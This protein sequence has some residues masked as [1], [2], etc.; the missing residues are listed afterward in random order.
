MK[1]PPTSHYPEP[2]AL[3]PRKVRRQIQFRAK[4]VLL[5]AATGFAFLAAEIILRLC[6]RPIATLNVETRGPHPDYGFAP[7]ASATGRFVRSEY[8]VGFQ[9]TAQRMRGSVIR[10]AERET[11][12]RARILFLGDSFTYS[13][14]TEEK[15]SFTSLL[16]RKWPDIEIIN[17]GCTGYGQREELAVLDKLGGELKPEITVV[18]FF[19]NDLEDVLRT[20]PAYAVNADGKVRRVSPADAPSDPLRLWPAQ[21]SLPQSKWHTCYV[22]ELIRQATAAARHRYTG[23]MRPR[24][25][26]T[27]EA[28]EH[29]WQLLDA[30]FRLIKIRAD[31]IGTRLVVI[32]IPD[33]N[34]VNP[35]STISS[36]KPLNFDVQARIKAVCEKNRIEEHDLL[37]TMQDAFKANGGAD[38]A[39]I[40]PL[41]YEF[42]RHLTVEGNRVI[43]EYLAS[44]LDPMLP[45]AQ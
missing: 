29:A 45:R 41:Y 25:I 31:E 34:L 32:A 19:W 12:T 40:R 33:Y 36:I 7:L 42:D 2:A 24:Q 3:Q 22:Y 28:M 13:I 37:E 1:T 16:S 30:Q 8:N 10:K 38:G 18:G 20:E 17:T 23:L 15:D 11:G 27:P 9:H 6:W 14:G 21:P 39:R 4:L 44:L 5:L 35:A 26:Q 43:A